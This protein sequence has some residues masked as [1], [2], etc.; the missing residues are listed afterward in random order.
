MR[1]F[2]QDL[3]YAIRQMAR[4]PGVT[5]FAALSLALGIGANST[6][7][8]L[9]NALLFR[10]LPGHR[11]QE[12][13][14]VY[15]G[16]EGEMQ[17]ATWSYP[18]FMDVRAWNDVFSEFAVINLTIA[19]WDDGQRTELLF[20]EQVSGNFFRLYGIQPVLGRDFLPEEDTRDGN[21]PVVLLGQRF[22]QRRFGGD[23]HI[24]GKTLKLNGQYLTVIGRIRPIQSF[25]SVISSRTRRRPTSSSWMTSR[26]IAPAFAAKRFTASRPI[27]T[28]PMARLPM[29]RVPMPTAARAV[30]AR[31]NASCAPVLG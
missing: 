4:K 18:D 13:V 31:A 17:Y 19:T 24:L 30:A 3:R 9:V 28:A 25:S 14:E 21:H 6:I 29:A 22:W 16:T 20:G 23:P 1:D 8:S 7:F 10:D 11:P 2:V 26:S 15:S 27:A 12:L 5:V